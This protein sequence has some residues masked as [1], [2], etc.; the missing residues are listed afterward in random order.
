MSKKVCIFDIDNTITHGETASKEICCAP[1]IDCINDSIAP[2]W[3]DKSG[4]TS[5]IKDAIENCRK[6]GYE[7]A[8]ATAE[9]G[10]EC[11]NPKQ[12][13]FINSLFPNSKIYGT[14]LYQHSCTA[15]GFLGSC[16]EGVSPSPACCDNEYSDKTNMYI[17]I[18]NKLEIPPSQYGNSIVFDDDMN[19]LA[20]ANRMGFMTCQASPNC[21]GKYCDKGCGITRSCS[22]LPIYANHI[23]IL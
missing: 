1:G 17:N 18:M 5:Y 8:I 7:L 16:T 10:N 2:A 13:K 6:N 21:G 9:S 15:Q 22:K 23:G 14:E 3:P 11:I 20:T 4:T 19:N 12:E